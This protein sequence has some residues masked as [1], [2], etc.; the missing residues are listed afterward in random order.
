MKDR[1]HIL[2]RV[3]DSEFA[4]ALCGQIVTVKDKM[5]FSSK[6]GYLHWPGGEPC[7]DCLQLA[8]MK[9]AKHVPGK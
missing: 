1:S 6:H 8:F 4:R 9:G 7:Q 2:T 3:L 5:P